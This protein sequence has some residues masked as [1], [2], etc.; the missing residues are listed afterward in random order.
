ML[1]LSIARKKL[2]SHLHELKLILGFI[3]APAV[4]ALIMYLYQI[5]SIESWELTWIVTVVL[6]LAYVAAIFLG[7]PTY[8]Y[9]RKKSKDSLLSYVLAGVLIGFTLYL[10]IFF[11]TV[12]FGAIS[13]SM[14]HAVTLFINTVGYSVFGVCSGLVS[15]IVF[16]GVAIR[17]TRQA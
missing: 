13:S 1:M 3:V 4:P 16:W 9:L 7:I 2:K 14:E 11:P 5:D 15:S 12:V 6:V 10:I 17:K 8:L